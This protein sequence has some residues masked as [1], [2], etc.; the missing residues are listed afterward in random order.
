[1]S[2]PS[3][4]LNSFDHLIVLMLENRSFDNLLG[5]LYQHDRPARFI[6][7]GEPE[8]RG[9]TG[10]DDLA[11]SDGKTPPTRIPVGKAPF[12]TPLDMCHP[13]PDPGEEYQPHVNRQLYGQDILPGSFDQ[14]KN[15]A[16]MSGFV[17]DYVRAI[18][19]QEF[20]DGI[21]PTFENYSRIM[22]CFTPEALPVLSGLARQFAVSDEWFAS[23]P[24]Q[25]WCNRSF[26]HSGQSHGFVTN[27]DG[28][29]WLENDAATVFERLEE[30]LGPD[31]GWRV[32]WDHQDIKPITRFIHRGLH[33]DRYAGGFRD[34]AGF[35]ADCHDGNL[36]AYT[37]IQPRLIINHNDMH[38]PVI[39]NQEVYSSVLAGEA[40]VNDIYDA[41][42]NGKNWMRSLLVIMFDEHG[43]CYDHWPPPL[44]TPPMAHPKYPMQDGFQFDRFGVRV[45]A[46]F[47]SPYIAPGTVIRAPGTVPF[48]HTSML[49]TICTR[50]KLDGLTDRDR[51]A[52]D[53]GAVC[54]LSEA[55][56]RRATP[57]MHPR[58]YT[59]ISAD[60]AHASLLHGFQKDFG[61]LIGHI[62]GRPVSAGIKRVGEL[63]R[64]L[65]GHPG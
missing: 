44:A 55:E 45:P 43:G 18:K 59:S 10:R 23:V 13:C 53:F 1:M 34:F 16:P 21:E 33:A 22:N 46:I 2:D 25:T 65:G 57:A 11:N 5:Y 30:A 41:V 54:T 20:W 31:R 35:A 60:A 56:A 42:R 6:G 17:E 19:S 12:E 14:L 27:V 51:A 7:R 15:P 28:I 61:R 32:Y 9:V 48:D 49:K 3:P 38:P 36:P 4:G 26:L 64:A 58:P 8:F 29:K 39:P 24:S 52:A 63:L 37:F 40:L 50:W 47:I 62:L